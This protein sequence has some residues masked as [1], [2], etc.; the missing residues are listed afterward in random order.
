MLLLLTSGAA[1]IFKTP[2]C[3]TLQGISQVSFMQFF[4]TIPDTFFRM[5]FPCLPQLIL[6]HEFMES[7]WKNRQLKYKLSH[8]LF[9]FM[10]PNSEIQVMLSLLICFWWPQSHGHSHIIGSP[11]DI[12]LKHF[13]FKSKFY[14]SV[15]VLPSF[16]IHNL[17][18]RRCAVT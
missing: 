2:S 12:T 11:G 15:I 5:S 8:M 1:W 10:Y 6:I 13:F 3:T 14:I 16:E 18:S 17:I 7:Y 4:E 9:W